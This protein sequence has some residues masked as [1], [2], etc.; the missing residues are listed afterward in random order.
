M[1]EPSTL[2]IASLAD[3]EQHLLSAGIVVLSIRAPSADPTASDPRGKDHDKWLVSYRQ[4]N[5]QLLWTT[6]KPKPTF[7]AAL[8]SCLKVPVKFDAESVTPATST[9]ELLEL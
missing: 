4:S 3:L 5:F 6:G 7:G 8:E 9:E 1:S 2:P